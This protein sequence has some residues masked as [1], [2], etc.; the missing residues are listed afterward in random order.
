MPETERLQPIQSIPLDVEIPGFPAEV[1][2]LLQ[3]D[4]HIMS[5]NMDEKALRAEVARAKRDNAIILINGD[6]FD[7][8]LPSDSKRYTPSAVGSIRDD[9]INE[10]LD[11]AVDVYKPVANQIAMVGMGNHEDSALKHHSVDLVKLFVERINAL[12]GDAKYGGYAGWIILKP[13]RERT[14]TTYKIRYHHGAG[15]SSPVTRGTIDFSRMMANISGADMLWIGHKH[16]QKHERYMQEYVS[17]Q[18]TVYARVT[19]AIMTGGY[20]TQLEGPVN[21]SLKKNMAHL[22][23]GGAMVTLELHRGYSNTMAEIKL[24]TVEWNPT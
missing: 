4:V 13:R 15:G 16:Y 10:A 12:G 23:V 1:K 14:L 9:L 5:P 19:E 8:I 21:Y 3:S 22:P 17:T 18:G 11:R 20:I 2:L 24:K 7:L 6:L